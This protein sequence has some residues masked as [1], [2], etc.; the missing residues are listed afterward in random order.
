[1]I[2]NFKKKFSK[3]IFWKNF[4]KVPA[5]YIS[6]GYKMTR[7]TLKGSA[8]IFWIVRQFWIF[9]QFIFMNFLTIAYSYIVYS[10][11]PVFPKIVN[12]SQNFQILTIPDFPRTVVRAGKTWKT[13]KCFLECS[14]KSY[15]QVGS[16]CIQ[17]SKCALW[18]TFVKKLS[19]AF[20]L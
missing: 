17:F 5:I 12:H 14:S 16:D 20:T 7:F 3:K 15:P 13:N 1:M 18:I 8:P 11:F 19:Q 9:P 10:R 2:Q 4:S 6:R